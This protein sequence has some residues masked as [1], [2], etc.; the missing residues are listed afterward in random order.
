MKQQSLITNFFSS[1]LQVRFATTYINSIM[2]GSET[3]SHI[4]KTF[5]LHGRMRVTKLPRYACATKKALTSLCLA[6]KPVFF[7]T[8]IPQKCNE[9]HIRTMVLA[10]NMHDGANGATA[11]ALWMHDDAISIMYQ[12][13]LTECITKVRLFRCLAHLQNRDSFFGCPPPH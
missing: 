3:T 10:A 6:V 7:A 2:Q 5:D 9:Q 8:Y 13:L 11:P 4:T 1:H 12:C